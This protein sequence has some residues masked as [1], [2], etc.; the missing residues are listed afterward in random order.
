[1]IFLIMSFVYLVLTILI[2][3]AQ[4]KMYFGV[5]SSL[6]TIMYLLN[7]KNNILKGK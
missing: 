3:D 2:P 6:F 7:V 4:A 1:M 5:Q